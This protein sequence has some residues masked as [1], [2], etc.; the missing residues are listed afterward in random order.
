MLHKVSPLL[1]EGKKTCSATYKSMFRH[2]WKNTNSTANAGCG[3]SFKCTSDWY[4]GGHGFDPLGCQHSFVEI[5]W[6]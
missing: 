2:A 1:K 3:S 4:S 5:N 6:S